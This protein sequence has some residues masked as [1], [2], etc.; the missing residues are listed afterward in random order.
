MDLRKTL[1][2]IGLALIV[3]TAMGAAPAPA[4]G[5][6]LRTA[7][8]PGEYRAQFDVAYMKDGT[9]EGKLDVY[10]RNRATPTPVV[11]WWHAGNG[12]KEQQLRL[13]LPL[14]ELGFSVVL[15]QA[16]DSRSSPSQFTI[17][18]LTSR[19]TVGRCALRWVMA[20]AD[21]YRF[22]PSKVVVAGVSLGGYTAL[23]TGLAASEAAFARPCPEGGDSKV[24]AVI[25][26]FGP[27]RLP[28][29]RQP[30]SS[31]GMSVVHPLSHVR[32]SSPPVLTVHGDADPTVPFAEGVEFNEALARA[33][34]PHDFL[35]I[36]G[37]QHGLS[38]WQP[39][40]L[41]TA[42]AKVRA[43]LQSYGLLQ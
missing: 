43:F 14:I 11:I 41:N 4:H 19:S 25:N 33:G 21:E 22:D 17:D 2:R 18:L 24:A 8:F 15:P 10:A 42:W 9:W 3:T 30:G 38:T 32:S 5:Q 27:I 7:S 23:M 12:A 26:F 37:G 20:H 1:K 6:A 36:P 13:A 31:G 16:R 28:S 29:E 34:A 35:R 40:Q 39:E